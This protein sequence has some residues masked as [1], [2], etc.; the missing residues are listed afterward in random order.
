MTVA[1]VEAGLPVNG[2]SLA[3]GND[4]LYSDLEHYRAAYDI[5]N[6]SEGNGCLTIK[7]TGTDPTYY[8][9]W[10]LEYAMDLDVISALCP[11]CRIVVVE[12]ASD[13]DSALAAAANVAA[14]TPGVDVVD[15]TYGTPEFQTDASGNSEQYYDTND[16]DHP[17]VAMV[18]ASGG[19]A[20][21]GSPS[22]TG[23]GTLMYPAASPDVI[24]VGG[25]VLSQNSTTK[26]WYDSSLYAGTDSGCS[27]YETAPSWQTEAATLCPGTTS[28]RRVDNDISAA[29]AMVNNNNL[30]NTPFPLVFDGSWWSGGGTALSADIISGIY[31]L[32]GPPAAGVNPASYLYADAAKSAFDLNDITSGSTTGCP[33]GS[34]LCTA[35]TG[36]DPPTGWG[37]PD[38]TLTLTPSGS[39][40]GQ[41]RDNSTGWCVDNFENG[42]DSGNKIDYHQCGGANETW[43][44]EADGTIRMYGGAY[45]I[46]T[47]GGAKTVGTTVVLWSCDGA[48]N[49]QWR[50]TSDDELY[51]PYANRCLDDPNGPPQ[52]GDQMAIEDCSATTSAEYLQQP[53]SVPTSTGEILSRAGTSKCVDN[54]GG[55]LTAGNP[56]QIYDCNGMTDTQQWTIAA[57]G[58]I[59][60][61]GDMCMDVGLASVVLA[62]CDHDNDALQMWIFLADG[63]L[64][65]TAVGECLYEPGLANSTLIGLNNCADASDEEWTLQ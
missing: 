16:Y 42:D 3:A 4:Q 9:N 8:G 33:A 51:N 48:A 52:N 31:A 38:T 36:W 19:N 61:G 7:T 5:P 21:S 39:V 65:N 43:T 44:V 49:Q 62:N 40:T 59:Q 58:S 29:A 24:S 63:N 22:D 28:P 45:C 53:Y 20:N 41:I 26:Q 2:D 55:V 30:D 46:G 50:F 11:N 35:T 12:S 14:T 13:E 32:A 23:Y 56:I 47:S 64:Y 57:D 15:N 1:L 60:I 37:T 54:T 6:C 17:G 34:Q 10:G 25:T 18:A 27:G